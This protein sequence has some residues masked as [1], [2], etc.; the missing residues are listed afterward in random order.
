MCDFSH[1]F[2]NNFVIVMYRFASEKLA[3]WKDSPSRKPLILKGIRQVGKTWLLKDFGK[4]SFESMAYINFEANPECKD[5]FERSLDVKRILKELAVVTGTRIEPG[6]TLLVLD[7]IQECPRALT[8]LKYFCEDAPELHVA[9][10]GS[11]LG[12]ALAKPASFPVGKVD[13]LHVNPM[14]F[15]EFLLADGQTNLAEFAS[16]IDK[17]E[18]VS[19]P[20]VSLF[21]EQLKT[22][23]VTGGMPAVIGQWCEHHNMEPLQDTLAS[24]LS[25]F[26]ADFGK[27][28]NKTDIPKISLIWRSLPSQLARENKKFLYQLVREGARAREYEN[29]LQWLTDGELVRKVFRSKAPGLPISAYD[30]LSAFKLYLSDV[31]LLRRLSNLLPTAIIEGDRL[32]TEFKGAL[33]ENFVLQSLAPQLDVEPRYW[34]Q[35]NPPHKVD[36]IVEVD[37]RIVPIEVK[38]DRN[39]RSRSLRVYQKRFPDATPLCV[40]FSLENLRLDGNLLNIPL[41][42]ADEAVRLIRIALSEQSRS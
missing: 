42:L 12:V 13:F 33:T 22:Y 31:G 2:I 21:E 38:S 11:L 20:I 39:V 3:A 34:S 1:T 35:V 8:A 7:E 28:P 27:H 10:A 4:N 36:F 23:Y 24:L 41:W 40:R 9:C 14:N 19:Q 32:F 29:A 18:P 37:N 30:D 5:Y 6:K 16:S 17:P 26:Q 15:T 25:A